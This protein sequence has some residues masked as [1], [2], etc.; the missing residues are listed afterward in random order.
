MK[1]NLIDIVYHVVEYII[2]GITQRHVFKMVD[3]ANGVVFDQLPG[4]ED[5]LW[6]IRLTGQRVELPISHILSI[7][8][9][10]VH[11]QNNQGSGRD[12]KWDNQTMVDHLNN[13][14]TDSKTGE[15]NTPLSSIKT[16]DGEEVYNSRKSEPEEKLKGQMSLF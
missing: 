16:A 13:A 10:D 3:A 9:Y 14:P 8:Q 5:W 12:S 15:V 11:W 6:G 2:D 7:K 1:S 4:R